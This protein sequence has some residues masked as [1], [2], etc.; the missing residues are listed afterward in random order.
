MLIQPLATI[1]ACF[2]SS[3]AQAIEDFCKQD[4]AQLADGRYPLLADTLAANLAT[5]QT[6]ALTTRLESHQKFLDLHYVLGQEQIAGALPENC[7]VTDPYDAAQDLTWWQGPSTLYP[8]RSGHAALIM[9]G[10]IHAAG[11]IWAAA[12]QVRKIVFKVA[13]PNP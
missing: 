9:P 2:S 3:V 6:H 11:I 1:L 10:E 12:A 4:F 8:L 7:T 13:W 5:Y